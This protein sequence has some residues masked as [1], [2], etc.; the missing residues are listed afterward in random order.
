MF[1]VVLLLLPIAGR[2]QSL[3]LPVIQVNICHFLFGFHVIAA[4]GILSVSEILLK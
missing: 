3:I 2:I 1:I 4:K